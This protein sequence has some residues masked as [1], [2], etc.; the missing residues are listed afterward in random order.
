MNKKMILLTLTFGFSG[1][2]ACTNS[3][4]PQ[5]AGDSSTR[6]FCG[7]SDR[8][9]KI[10]ISNE[11]DPKFFTEAQAIKEGE[12]FVNL[13]T[14]FVRSDADDPESPQL[15]VSH[16]SL[17]E[18]MFV[19]DIFLES[20]FYKNCSRGMDYE[21]SGSFE[22]TLPV[23]LNLAE[24]KTWN[25]IS[26]ATYQIEYGKQFETFLNLKASLDGTPSPSSDDRDFKEV[27]IIERVP[28][29]KSKKSA[30][31]K[32][33]IL[34]FEEFKQYYGRFPFFKLE[35]ELKAEQQY[36]DYLKIVRFTSKKQEVV[37]VA[38]KIEDKK[39][40]KPK[41][42]FLQIQVSDDPLIYARAELRKVE[43]KDVEENKKSENTE[44]KEDQEA[45][46]NDSL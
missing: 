26:S 16:G 40:E 7:R 5:Y 32:N 46:A 30:Q 11:L 39:D 1:L 9:Y 29:E 10:P 43:D 42:I 19:K 31:F 35:N 34:T 22:V 21:K 8:D 2:I 28:K 33:K 41:T 12:Y 38:P 27:M 15:M 25:T 14:I 18:P 17:R 44:E 36:K 6:G 4:T 20:N 45:A 24:D 3:S 23:K 13:L 37:E